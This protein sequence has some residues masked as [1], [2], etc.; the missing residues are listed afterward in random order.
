MTIPQLA[1]D[2]PLSPELVLVLPPERRAQVLASLAPPAWA[3]PTLRVVPR[4]EPAAEPP[5]VEDEPLGRA[6]GR[7]LAARVVQLGVIFA[8]ATILTLALSL[9]AHAVR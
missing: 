8:V 4:A 1:P 6:M 5:A 7:F 9:V 3:A 2:E